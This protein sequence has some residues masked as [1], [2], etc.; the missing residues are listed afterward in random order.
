MKKFALVVA[1]ALISALVTAEAKEPRFALVIGNGNYDDL[2]KLKNPANDAAD[3]AKA[4]K[5]LGFDVELLTDADIVQMEEAVAR[6]GNKLSTDHASI[7]FFFYAGH[8][9]Q[10]GGG[11]Y[12]IPVG[13]RI[14]SESYLK[15]RALDSQAIMEGI[16]GAGNKLNVIIL[17]ACRNNPFSWSRSGTRGLTVVGAQPP[18]S[19]V[20]Y[21]TSAGSVAQDGTGRNGIFTAELLKNLG[22]PGVEIG[23]MFKRT[24]AA[25]QQVTNGQ[26]IPAIYSQYFSSA[27]LNGVAKAPP[28]VAVAPAETP[29][30]AVPGKPGELMVRAAE[31]GSE[32]FVDGSLKGVSPLL[33]P[34][35]PSGKALRVEARSP[36]S[37]GSADVTLKPGELKDIAVAMSQRK[38]N[39]VIA[40]DEKNVRVVID[41][42]D[43]G[44]L[45]A[46]LFRD[47]AV[48]THK[49]E[50]TGKDLYFSQDV[51]ID[52]EKSAQVN[53]RV[54]PVG[55]LEIKAPADAAI[56]VKGADFN[57][58]FSGPSSIA[59]LPAGIYIAEAGGGDYIP[60]EKQFEVKK[61]EKAVWEPYTAGTVDIDVE[62]EDALIEGPKG[63]A[64]RNGSQDIAP[65]SYKAIVKKE[66]YRQREMSFTVVLGKR[67]AV[68]MAL[69]Q[70]GYGSVVIPRYALPL[71][72]LV[73]DIRIAGKP[74]G[75]GFV[76][77]GGI[78]MGASRTMAFT[79]ASARA[80]EVRSLTMPIKDGETVMLTIP[81]GRLSLPFLAEGSNVEIDGATV[82]G[83]G[84]PWRSEPLPA[85]T[86]EVGVIGPYPFHSTVTIDEGSTVEMPGYRSSLID[87]LTRNIDEIERSGAAGKTQKK[88]GTAFL[89]AG[90]AAAACAGLSF[91]LG[92]SAK[93][94]YDAAADSATATSAR[95]LVD[96]WSA[97]FFAS[98]ATGGVGLTLSP[99]L[100]LSGKKANAELNKKAEL[101]RLIDGLSEEK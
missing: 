92:A 18:G 37:Y 27:Y 13:A 80:A 83:A 78:P 101:Q 38:G 47:L 99:V 22:A 32:I 41:G 50:L 67:T 52:E 87:G 4:L 68:S 55:N 29:A 93:T 88:L 25:V 65:G 77:Y 89:A 1:L 82:I 91:I 31:D 7:G 61:G 94:D 95:D 97:A 63:I 49:L 40:S 23:D 69:D 16:K 90:L 26:Q 73:D 30:P 44:A 48:G 76:R 75:D 72:L 33:V 6:L 60:V 39:L 59:R 36:K 81:S 62:P 64:L 98:A 53:A 24:G 56:K 12:L 5:G 96:F 46:G 66:G 35:L 51:T 17:D 79:T 3:M 8:G 20:V 42:K 2:G 28:A 70:A 58:S 43:S 84:K 45:G 74:E 11:N 14:P 9:V 15:M 19:I 57:A 21:A 86:Y 85:G 100:F 34:N 10:S 71:V 54:L